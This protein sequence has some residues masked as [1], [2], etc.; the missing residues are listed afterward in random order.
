MKDYEPVI[1]NAN[2]FKNVKLIMSDEQIKEEE[3]KVKGLAKYIK[4]NAIDCLISN[5]SK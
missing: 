5:F 3:E 1:F 4:E 2:V